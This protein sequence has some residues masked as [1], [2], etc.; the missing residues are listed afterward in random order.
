[1]TLVAGYADVLGIVVG[2]VLCLSGLGLVLMGAIGMADRRLRRGAMGIAA[3]AAVALL[4][5]WLVGVL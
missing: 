1:M 2:V 4:G 5:F 3:G